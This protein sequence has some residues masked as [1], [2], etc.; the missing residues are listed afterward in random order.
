[1]PENTELSP[2]SDSLVAALAAA[3]IELP[4]E[5]LQMLDRYREALW[6]YNQQLN[7]TRHTT[8]DKFVT[9]DVVDS[10]ELAK[11]I[12]AGRRVLDVGSGGG[13]PGLI[14]AICRPDLQ[15]SVCESTQKKARVLQAMIDELGLEVETH[16]CRVEELLPLRRFD[17][18]VARAVAPLPKI[19]Y[20]LQPHWEA[21]DELLLTKGRSWT[22]ERKE[23]RHRGLLNDLALRC[24]ASYETIGFDAPSVILRLCPKDQLEDDDQLD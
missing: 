5:Q 22:E 23:A 24:A 1:M 9:R 8:F 12:A 4:D 2:Q 13:V 17:V 3:G 16:A 11:Q 18:L 19:L 7:L 15:V 6:R 10:L 20:W 21:F 14:L